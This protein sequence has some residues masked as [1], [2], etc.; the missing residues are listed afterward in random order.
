MKCC[1]FRDASRTQSGG[2]YFEAHRAG[3]A[4]TSPMLTSSPKTEA[5]V[6]VPTVAS[7]LSNPQPLSPT[8]DTP[9]HPCF[10]NRRPFGPGK[11][12]TVRK[13]QKGTI[14]RIS[15]R[16]YLRYW[17]RRNISGTLV[18]KRTSYCLGQVTT[19]GVRPS[20]DIEKAAEDYMQTVNNNVI[21]AEHNVNLSDFVE[22][23]YLPWIKQNRRPSTYKNCRDVWNDHL[24]PVSSRDRASLR[25]TRTFTVQKWLN[26]IGKEDLSRN[27]LKRI[28]STISGVFTLAKQL[29][30]F[31]G[32]N[33]VQGT[34]VNPHAREAEETYA[35]SLEEINSM[36]TV[37]P[38]PAST[39]FAVA[40][41]TGLRK[42]E[43]EGLEWP[44][45]HDGALWVSR[46]IWNGRE[47]PTKTKKSKAPVPVIRQLADRLELHRFRCGNPN[48]GPI[49][50]SGLG[51]RIS[52][53]NLVNRHMLP[54]LNRCQHCGFNN[55]KKHVKQNHQYERDEQLPKWHGWHAARRGLGSN[56]YRLGVPD[57]VIQA[58]LRHSNVNV[59]LGY[60]IKPQ[61][62]DVVAAM[63]KFEAEI[64]A[65][66][67][68]DTNRTLNRTPGATPESV[69]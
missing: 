44:D 11:R 15:G 7:P 48:T 46:S 60:Y 19:R 9:V 17:E 12:R 49:F 52:T 53:N 47:L 64:A 4:N 43:I 13:K 68:R 61:T 23:V 65:H 1:Q 34:S 30:Y 51:T 8:R 55:D 54:A 37:F 63:G 62:P 29:G 41:F 2:V 56:L 31:D 16:W 3:A 40:A 6:A 32:V 14:A 57:K 33:P 25:E 24:Q 22:S 35:Y 45:F 66:D 28:K 21:P 38:E 36:L 5:N 18:R 42:G 58:I 27:S 10:I 39:A 67:F 59:T 26:Q 69:N 50:A 20:A